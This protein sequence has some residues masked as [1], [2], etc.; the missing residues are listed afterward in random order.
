MIAEDAPGPIHLQGNNCEAPS[1]LTIGKI[2]KTL[3]KVIKGT[4][5]AADSYHIFKLVILK[6]VS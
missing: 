4:E 3:F 1:I 6:T 5:V 2:W